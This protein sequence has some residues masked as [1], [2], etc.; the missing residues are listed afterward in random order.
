MRKLSI[1]GN[2]TVFKTP[3]I[4]KIVHL[5]LVKVVPNSVILKLIK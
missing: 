5:A 2:T 4:S 3:A 1:A